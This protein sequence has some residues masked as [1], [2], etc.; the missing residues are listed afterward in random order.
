[1]L[2]PSARSDN[3]GYMFTCPSRPEMGHC[4]R[5][6]KLVMICSNFLHQVKLLLSLWLY[7][8]AWAL[9]FLL[10]L[11]LL[12]L[13]SL[14]VL[15]LLLLLLPPTPPPCPFHDVTP[16]YPVWGPTLAF[17]MAIVMSGVGGG[18]F[19]QQWGTLDLVLCFCGEKNNE[20]KILVKKPAKKKSCKKNVW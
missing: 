12:L 13:L 19:R 7:L 16:S 1:M 15:L 9:S 20:K 11:H 17:N 14:L 6:A 10:L 4:Y 2:Q 5:T 3:I 8:T 18:N